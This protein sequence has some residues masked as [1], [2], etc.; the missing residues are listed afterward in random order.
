MYI[1]INSKKLVGVIVEGIT[2]DKVEAIIIGIGI[3]INNESFN[4]EVSSIASS[5]YLETK[6]KLEFFLSVKKIQ[7]GDINLFGKN[8]FRIQNLKFYQ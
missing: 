4:S 7:N 6:K 2:T 1:I 3:N 5:L 8:L